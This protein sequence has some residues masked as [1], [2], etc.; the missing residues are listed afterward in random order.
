[1]KIEWEKTDTIEIQDCG[2][3]QITDEKGNLKGIWI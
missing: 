3:I 1:M 2:G